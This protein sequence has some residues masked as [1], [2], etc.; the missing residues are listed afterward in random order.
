MAEGKQSYS[1]TTVYKIK[2]TNKD[3]AKQNTP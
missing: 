2:T 1:Q 3:F